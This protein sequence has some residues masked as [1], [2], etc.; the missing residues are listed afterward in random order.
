ML[1]VPARFEIAVDVFDCH[2]CV[3]DQNTDGQR[4]SAQ[5]HDIDGLVQRVEY[6]ERAE[7][8]E[9]NG[10]RDDGRGAPTAQKNQDHKRSEADGYDG[11][12]G[13]A[14]D[15]PA[16]E[17]RL[18]G[19][20]FDSDLRRQLVFDREEFL[21]H[22]ADNVQRGG[23]AGLH[24]SHHD[25]A[26]AVYAQYVGLWRIAVA[27]VGHIADVDHRSVHSLDWHVVQ[28]V[29]DLQSGVGLHRV[30]EAVDLHGA[31][32]RDEVLGG[33]G[34]DHVGGRQT[35]GLERMQIDVHLHLARLAAVGIGRLRA[36]NGRQ[37]DC[38]IDS[39]CVRQ[40]LFV[41]PLP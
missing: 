30:L 39:C 38:D 3:I 32:G 5:G 41:H 2:G 16:D 36:L 23:R 37:L 18:I 25:A 27:Y 35:L 7:N 19:E 9:R 28:L 6:G 20:G 17:D 31:G 1:Q 22:A 34:V 13:Y 8:R 21:F 11:L 10:Y 40:L 4:Q 12:A 26:A 33:D 29:N 24:D 15:G 14:V